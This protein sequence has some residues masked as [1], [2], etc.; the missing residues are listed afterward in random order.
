M[1]EAV[2]EK[3]KE[4][5]QLTGKAL[6]IDDEPDLC[7]IIKRYLKK[8]GLQV[9]TAASGEEGLKMIRNDNYQYLI[10][11]LKLPGLD[12]QTLIKLC[13]DENLIENTIAIVITG[14]LLNEYSKEEENALQNNIDGFL[15][16]FFSKDELV[17][18]LGSFEPA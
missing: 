13:K 17:A 4:T 8:S 2:L 5:G 11:D 6:V 15:Q 16:N 18:L 3:Q 10:T 1:N 12:G 7:K 9:D 14:G